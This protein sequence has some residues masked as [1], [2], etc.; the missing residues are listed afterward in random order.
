[1]NQFKYNVDP[2]IDKVFIYGFGFTGKWLT[3]NIDRKVDGF[4]DTD[5]KK[6]GEKFNGVEVFSYEDAKNFVDP[7]TE[8]II[9]TVDIFDVVPLI[10]KLDKQKVTPIGYFLD[11]TKANN[12]TTGEQDEYIEY[13][14]RTVEYSHKNYR[15]K[16]K[17]FIRSLDLMITERCSLKCQ[18]C[19]NLMQYYKSPK[20]MD[21]E[22]LKKE[23][24]IVCEKFDFINEIRLIGGEPFMN[25]EIYKILEWLC[26]FKKFEK[27]VIY[28][29]ATIPLKEDY[30]DILQNNKIIFS[31]T[32]YGSLSKNTKVVT[33]FLDKYKIPYRIHTPEYWTD[34]GR[35]VYENNN[36]TPAELKEFFSDCCAKNLYTVL[37][38]KIYRCPFVANADNLKA[39]PNDKNNYVSIHDTKEN[40]KNHLYNTEYLPG[41][42]YCKG[43]SFESV[44]I[45]PAIQTKRIFDYKKLQD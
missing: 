39:I 17:L 34:S 18:D 12:N 25:K 20:N 11:N 4:I 41:C 22:D 2:S 3:S 13:S 33:D 40:I 26:E 42:N 14:L 38:E 36:K 21:F 43:R 1:M 23:M 32:D 10:D 7:K 6:K 35:L 28:T 15:D 30:S 24:K 16:N 19:S 9:S 37:G 44:E 5:I 29:N 31:I 27:I 8:I 45:K